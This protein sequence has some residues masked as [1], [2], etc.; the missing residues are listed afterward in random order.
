[1]MRSAVLESDTWAGAED[2]TMMVA[3]SLR[4]HITLS[5]T[6][7]TWVTSQRIVLVLSLVTTKNLLD[8]ALLKCGGTVW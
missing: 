3:L 1:M 7:P 6:W 4:F 2:A 5:L 8:N